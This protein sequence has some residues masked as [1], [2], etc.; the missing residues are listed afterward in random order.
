MSTPLHPK[1]ALALQQPN[2]VSAAEVAEAA[3]FLE[4]MPDVLSVTIE[5][6]RLVL[7]YPECLLTFKH[8]PGTP[9]RLAAALDA[10]FGSPN[11]QDE[12]KAA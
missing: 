6:D 11:P 10:T 2:A 5:D 1:L 4:T 9:E 3:A 8:V 7:D 12:R